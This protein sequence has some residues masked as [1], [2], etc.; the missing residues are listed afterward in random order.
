MRFQSVELKHYRVLENAHIVRHIVEGAVHGLAGQIDDVIANECEVHE[1]MQNKSKIYTPTSW[2]S[3]MAQ[4]QT[5]Q[6]KP[7]DV[8]R[9]KLSPS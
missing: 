2:A 1:Q 9:L 6:R 8:T 5:E 4:E 3:D 7:T